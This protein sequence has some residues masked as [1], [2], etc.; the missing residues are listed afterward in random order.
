MAAGLFAACVIFLAAGVLWFYVLQPFLADW[1]PRVKPSQPA[2]PVPRRKPVRYVVMKRP[3]IA[4]SRPAVSVS[5]TGIKPVSLD[6]LTEDQLFIALARARRANGDYL[7]SG[8]KIYGLVGGNYNEFLVKLRAARE[9][10]APAA[11]P[12]RAIP[13]KQRTGEEYLL[14]LSA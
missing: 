13:V 9:Q 1:Q 6:N 11:K 7:H 12:A 14:D 8:K 4:V 2:A 10:D 5:D 3:K